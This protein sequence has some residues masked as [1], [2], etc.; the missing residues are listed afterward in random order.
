MIILI[1]LMKLIHGYPCFPPLFQP[2]SQLAVQLTL[3]LVFPKVL[4]LLFRVILQ[5]SASFV[6]VSVT[7]T[8]AVLSPITSLLALSIAGFVS[9]PDLLHLGELH[10]FSAGFHT[11]INDF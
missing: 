6:V 1:H 11:F 10:Y 8:F 3:V 5:L 7:A 9:S 2:I 4:A